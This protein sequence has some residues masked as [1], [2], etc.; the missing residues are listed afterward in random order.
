MKLYFKDKYGNQI[1]T[2]KVYCDNKHDATHI[3]ILHIGDTW[4]AQP[5]ELDMEE[6]KDVCMY[7]EKQEF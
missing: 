3:H 1:D 2:D 6:L 4:Y 7:L 5:C